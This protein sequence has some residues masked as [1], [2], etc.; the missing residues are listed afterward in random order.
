MV[1]SE[2]VLNGQTWAYTIYAIVIIIA[3]LGFGY[4]ITRK[5][6]SGVLKTSLFVVLVILLTVL[7]VSLHLTTNKTIPWVSMDL[8]RSD[9]TPDK[10]FDITMADHKFILPENKMQV[11]VGDI[12]LF[13]VESQD[14]TYGFGIFRE[15]HSMVCQ[16]QV[17]PGHIN[18]LMWKFEKPGTYTIRSTE[19][20]GPKGHKMIV[21]NAL[22]VIK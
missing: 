17:V 5:G 10:E 14:L 15:N 16:M 12:V 6:K 7:G 18:D 3:M 4:K 21:K 19:Y 13:N 20:S 2:L 11:K 8:N 1:D 22:E 9:I